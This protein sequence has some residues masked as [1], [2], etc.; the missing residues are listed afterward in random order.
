MTE[1]QVSHPTGALHIPEILDYVLSFFDDEHDPWNWKENRDVLANA[2]RVDHMWFGHAVR[3]LWCSTLAGR[4]AAIPD[5]QRRQIY[6]S[7]I[8]FMELRDYGVDSHFFDFRDLTFPCL[9]SITLCPS[10]H[11]PSDYQRELENSKQLLQPALRYFRSQRMNIG[12]DALR[13]LISRCPNIE[14]FSIE[15]PLSL[16][17]TE[18]FVELLSRCRHLRE[19]QAESLGQRD[20]CNRVLFQ[21]GTLEKLE[22]LRWPELIELTTLNQ[23]RQLPHTPFPAIR[24]LEIHLSLE[25]LQTLIPMVPHLKRLKLR[26]SGD[27]PTAFRLLA[28][29]TRLNNLLLVLNDE[30]SF[31]NADI[32]SLSTLTDL[33]WLEIVRAEVEAD[34]SQNWSLTAAEFTN[35]DF[36][37]LVSHFPELVRLN[38]SVH[39]PEMT[40]ADAALAI[41]TEHCAWLNYC[42]LDLKLDVRTII[43]GSERRHLIPILLHLGVLDI[44]AE[45]ADDPDD[46]E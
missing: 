2:M 15:E 34:V 18:C 25:A 5:P 29:M 44:V 3:I 9:R 40:T 11:N 26:L 38:F 31:A 37:K 21:L 41:L 10:F 4:L 19:F 16:P 35:D 32:L 14:K 7:A 39:C 13:Y 8:R 24:R 1:P 12:H 27:A 36:A 20:D 43:E 28:T 23:I 42:T 22:S 6:A 46:P 17:D 30:C 33:Y 45:E